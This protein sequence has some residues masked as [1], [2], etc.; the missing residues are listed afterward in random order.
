MSNVTP[1]LNGI[2]G[3]LKNNVLRFVLPAFTLHW[4]DVAHGEIYGVVANATGNPTP[5]PSQV[6]P[7]I[8]APGAMPQS[9]AIAAH[10]DRRLDL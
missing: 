5:S 4:R 1:E 6:Q 7:P 9:R 8:G 10:A 3:T 2:P